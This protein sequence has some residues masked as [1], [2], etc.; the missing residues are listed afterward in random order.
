MRKTSSCGPATT[1]PGGRASA[2][3]SGRSGCRAHRHRP[4]QYGGRDR[5]DA[6]ERASRHRDAATAAIR[7]D[8]RLISRLLAAAEAGEERSKI[9]AE[10]VAEITAFLHD[11]RRQAEPGDGL[12]DAREA[13][14]RHRK[15]TERIA[16]EGVEA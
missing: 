12:A 1:M 2:R 8:I 5:R 10:F 15:S 13:R 9:V 11:D 7:R 4:L 14:C 6:G 3:H 16:F